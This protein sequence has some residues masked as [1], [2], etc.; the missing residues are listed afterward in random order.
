MTCVSPPLLTSAVSPPTARRHGITTV[1]ELR[2][3]G[4][5]LY[6]ELHLSPGSR[7]CIEM[8]EEVTQPIPR[9]EIAEIFDAFRQIAL[10]VEPLA[11]RLMLTGSYRRG[12]ASGHDIDV[13]G[14]IADPAPV[15]DDSEGGSRRVAP[16]KLRVIEALIAACTA[17]GLVTDTL[18]SPKEEAGVGGAFAG[19]F[20]M[21]LCKL[22]RPGSFHRRVDIRM[23]YESGAGAALLHCTGSGDFN[24]K[25]SE[26]ANRVR[27]KS[28][29]APAPPCTSTPT[30]T[31]T[32][33]HTYIHTHTHVWP[34]TGFAHASASWSSSWTT[35]RASL[36]I[37]VPSA[38]M[39]RGAS[40]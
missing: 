39:Y 25:M 20:F 23:F 8:H 19:C 4:A 31:C 35:L 13:L 6:D 5:P 2:A 22:D 1:E 36:L 38:I 11:P 28:A 40:S 26:I 29:Q 10:T 9:A 12:K 33:L 16:T 7:R 18:T 30:S 3:H 14:F 17:A 21:G 32:C 15:D 27:K 24:R 37:G 34:P